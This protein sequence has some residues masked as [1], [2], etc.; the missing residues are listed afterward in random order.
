M[1]LHDYNE[2]CPATRQR[3]GLDHL[4]LEELMMPKTTTS[5]E[6]RFWAK[7]D[8]RGSADHP[9]C[10]VWTAYTLP[11]GYGMFNLG[12]GQK[13]YS[14]RIAYAWLV[15]PIADGL[16]T[17]HLCRNRACC[18]PAHLEPVTQRENVRRGDSRLHVPAWQAASAATKR[19]LD[20][21]K[22][23]HA[24][25]EANTIRRASGGRDCRACQAAYQR[26]L[27]S[28]RRRPSAP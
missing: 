26:R 16:V 20:H 14:H 28:L 9:F 15:E 24:F 5:V 19:A 2:K 1:P 3:P 25:D 11:N 21:C 4:L 17:D 10:W 7:V 8:K 22:H 12:E 23:G 13:D 6:E 18:N 27:R